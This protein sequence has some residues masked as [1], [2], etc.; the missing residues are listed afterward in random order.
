ML[1]SRGLCGLKV[2]LHDTQ[3]SQGL[4]N[5]LDLVVMLFYSPLVHVEVMERNHKN[6]DGMECFWWT[7]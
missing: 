2:C 6:K 7:R 1:V 5:V 3:G 4:I